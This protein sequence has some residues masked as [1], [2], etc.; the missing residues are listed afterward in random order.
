MT[1][2][3]LE[4]V[5]QAILELLEWIKNRPS[6]HADALIRA[7]KG[8]FSPKEIIELADKC[9]SESQASSLPKRSVTAEELSVTTSTAPPVTLTQISNAQNVNKLAANQVLQFAPAGL[10]VIYGANGTGKSGY[11]RL[12][13]QVCQVR[14]LPGQVLPN[15]YAQAQGIPKANISWSTGNGEET[16]EWTHGRTAAAA[17]KSVSVFDSKA[18]DHHIH[19]GAQAAYTP[20]ALRLLESLGSA[21]RQV[22]EELQG[23]IDAKIAG[24]TPLT[25]LHQDS[26]LTELMSALGQEGIET[27]IRMASVLT[28]EE[29][30]RLA[31]LTQ[32]LEEA[33]RTDPSI[34]I[35]S[36]K[37]VTKEAEELIE[38]LEV[39]ASCLDETQ[40]AASRDKAEDVAGKATVAEAS[41]ALL[42]GMELPDLGGTIWKQLWDAARTYSRSSAYPE[43]AFPHVDGDA[44][45]VLCQ[46]ILGQEAKRRMES[47]EKHVHDK[48]QQD[49]KTARA[50][51]VTA[52]E[53]VQRKV[54]AAVQNL[55]PSAELADLSQELS[56]SKAIAPVST[57]AKARLDFMQRLVATPSEFQRPLAD[58]A[59][60]DVPSIVAS[61]QTAIA[62]WDL[63]MS[64]LAEL[65]DEEGQAK[66][67][68][69]HRTLQDREVLAANL[70]P[71][72]AE[73]RRQTDLRKLKAAI[74]TT[75][76][77][78]VTQQHGKLSQQLVT[79]TLR[80]IF[81]DELQQ[82][83]AG[84]LQVSISRAGSANAAST[85]KLTFDGVDA[86]NALGEVFSEGECRIISLAR[87]LTELRYSKSK[88]AIVMDDPVSSLDHKY[89]AKV[90]KRLAIEALERQVVIF[91]HDIAFLE[92]LNH[93][94]PH[95]GA[96][97]EYRVLENTSAGAGTYSGTLPPY[98]ANLSKRLGYIRNHLQQN[99]KYWDNKADKEWR[100]ASETLVREMR[101]A[102]ERAIEEVLF[103]EAV[104]RFERAVQTNRVRTVT[105]DDSDWAAIENAMTELSRLGP[106]DEPQEAQDEPPS[107]ADIKALIQDLEDWKSGVAQKRKATE[108]RRPKVTAKI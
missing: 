23:R 60:W 4:P 16:C 90:A 5:D 24:P 34:K 71:V 91:T 68:K 86:K 49:L 102:W 50:E 76:R 45:C 83:G 67:R 20:E 22:E 52:F 85:F 26:E 79:E 82:L 14:G 48:A 75:K 35:A 28:P 88:A 105:V 93:H 108:K 95:T 89:R 12:L 62:D 39:L 72:L 8:P 53:L 77:N 51:T 17:L 106:H 47:L 84:R 42:A 11:T 19:D 107:P 27:R 97:I 73:N 2:E 103:N 99:E 66:L 6:W 59:E 74:A 100:E 13:R 37:R 21:L 44:R 57:A 31:E 29:V 65:C 70:N 46:Q 18:A 94:A 78:A 3:S 56:F 104:T 33:S 15:I 54:T 10:T 43:H 32:A 9:L 55:V 1:N 40:I 58:D 101:K 38:N 87:F 64:G 41:A 7:S 63:Q 98:G 69:E 30:E 92:Q 36:L 81:N 25:F 96:D 61:F 80:E